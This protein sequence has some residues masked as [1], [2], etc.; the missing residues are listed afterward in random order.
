[1][2]ELMTNFK[3]K[4][5]QMIPLPKIYEGE[6]T[7]DSEGLE[8][9]DRTRVGRKAAGDSGGKP[10]GSGS[11]ASKPGG[12]GGAGGS[13]GSSSGAGGS[14]GGGARAGGSVGGSSGARGSGG[15]AG[16]GG[17]DKDS[18]RGRDDDDP[19]N[20]PNKCRKK[21]PAPKRPI[22]RKEPWQ[23][24]PM[25]GG[26]YL[27]P[28]G[29]LPPGRQKSGSS[30]HITDEGKNSAEPLYAPLDQ[31]SAAKD[32]PGENGGATGQAA[33]IQGRNSGTL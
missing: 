10:G 18:K 6:D 33:Q 2:Q 22:A 4:H 19:D 1:M 14:R 20:D 24:Q 32:T 7:S 29:C 15:S 25:Y 28:R 11:S 27:R 21:D 16:G 23:G 8:L 5:R 17:P 12:S 26:Q 31:S 30:L 13:A 3:N 9:V